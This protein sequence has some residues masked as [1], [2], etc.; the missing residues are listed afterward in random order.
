M[1]VGIISNMINQFSLFHSVDRNMKK[2]LFGN[3]KTFGK[4]FMEF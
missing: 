4:F 3:M 1:R 2:N